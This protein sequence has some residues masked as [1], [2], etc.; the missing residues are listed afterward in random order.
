MAGTDA[1]YREAERTERERQG[2]FLLNNVGGMYHG[3]LRKM[4]DYAGGFEEAYRIPAGEYLKCGILRN[5]EQG[6]AVLMAY[7]R[8]H[9]QE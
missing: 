2:L 4:Y 3:L 5:N 9:E 7:D 1:D 6:K 8:R